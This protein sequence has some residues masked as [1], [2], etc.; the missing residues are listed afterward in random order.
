[1]DEA[2]VPQPKRFSIRPEW[3]DNRLSFVASVKP[4]ATPT[5]SDSTKS[6]MIQSPLTRQEPP[7][8]FEPKVVGLYKRLFRVRHLL[9]V[10]NM[11]TTKDPQE[12][13]D[14]EKTA[15]FWRE[16]FLLKPDIPRLR[17][18]L[19]DTDADF[20]LHVQVWYKC[21]FAYMHTVF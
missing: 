16:L 10:S 2:G 11:Q 4:V 15:G 20:L 6:T 8:V 5:P 9:L 7:D 18:I 21:L 19:N 3:R 1:M 13:E 17:Q 12:V 14:D